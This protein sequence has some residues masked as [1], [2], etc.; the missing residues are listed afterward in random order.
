MTRSRLPSAVSCTALQLPAIDDVAD[1]VKVAAVGVTQEVE[2]LAGLAA[3]GAEVDVGNEDG[4][5]PQ[6]GIPILELIRV[7][8]FHCQAIVPAGQV[9]GVSAA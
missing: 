9:N 3:R 4:A 7:P 8:S 5:E 1:E 6:R 2:E